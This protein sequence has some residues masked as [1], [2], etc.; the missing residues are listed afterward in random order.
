TGSGIFSNASKYAFLPAYLGVDTNASVVGLLFDRNSDS[1][2]ISAG[3]VGRDDTST[4]NSESYGGWFNSLFAGG[5]HVAMLRTT[6]STLF[7]ND[8]H[9]FI[10]HYGTSPATI[11]LPGSSSRKPGKAI[12][13]IRRNVIALKI[14][15]NGTMI[16][17]GTSEVT[18]YEID[19]AGNVWS[20]WW[21]GQVWIAVKL[22]RA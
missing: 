5:L 4:G 13:V 12:F 22:S 14:N 18:E 21:D 1:E 9:T 20:F 19:D 6:A 15:A 11:Y 10:V 2:G 7:L 17:R 3:V 8:K 16:A